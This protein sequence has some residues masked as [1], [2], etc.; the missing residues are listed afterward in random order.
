MTTTSTMTEPPKP[1]R[2]TLRVLVVEDETRLREMLV[3][4]VNDMGFSAQ[5]VGN[6][7]SAART[8]TDKSIDI[9]VL[10]LNLPGMNGMELFE[11]IRRHHP[12]T[13]V[14]VL[15][16]FGDLEAAQKAIHFDAVDFLTKPCALGELERSLDRARVRLHRA[17]TTAEPPVPVP[18]TTS[19]PA[20]TLEA[21]ERQH[22]LNT[23]EKNHGNR[24]ATA[25]ELGI[26][27]RKL[28]YR[29]GQY[30]REGLLP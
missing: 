7:E 3:R 13:Q 4:A 24:A 6:A 18:S 1:I 26:S 30:Q 19:A 21:V 27:L 14:I 28:Y 25:A 15:T 9:A 5:G 20:N 29:L 2:T 10:D 8:M 23:L 17:S 16:G 11:L 22:I 12:A